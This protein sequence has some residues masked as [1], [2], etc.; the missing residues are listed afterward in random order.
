MPS[1]IMKTYSLNGK[2]L[3]KMVKFQKD[4]LLGA[5]TAAHQVEGGN[6]HSD[7][8]ALENIPHTAY[9]E[10]SGNA[11]DHYHRY[12]EDIRMLEK[13]GFN[14]YRFS[15]EWARIEPEEGKFD[16][17][18]IEHYRRVIRCCKAHRIEPMITLLHFSSPAWLISK[19]GWETESVIDDFVRYCS[20]VIEH[21]G[22]EVKYVCTINELNIRLQIA[23]IIQ[24]YSQNMMRAHKQDPSAERAEDE[25]QMG[26]N[27]K[28]LM[29]RQQ[30]S[31]EEG[32]DVFGLPD[33]SQMHVF[34]S[35]CSLAGDLIL[36]KA[37]IAARGAIKKICPDLKVGLT[38]SLHDFQAQQ[39]GEKMA[40]KEWDKEF[41]HYLPFIS[42]DD[43]L[44]VQNYTRTL[45]GPEGILPFPENAEL[46]QT[47]YEYYPEALEHVVR[48]VA[49]G[50]SGP[51][52]VT[53]NGIATDNDDRRIDFISTAAEGVSRCIA[54]GISVKGYFYWSLLDNFEWQKGFSKTFGLI[55]VDRKTMK[56]SPKKSLEFLG[57]MR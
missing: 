51:I 32:A 34:Q 12:E 10:R 29:E 40:E 19:G 49:E 2:G 31:E 45:V 14:A 1:P 5:A 57:N 16:E 22:S 48:K 4:F 56:R 3:N 42:A 39:G 27:M 53:E 43:F 50:F 20:Y 24:R 55:A 46:T 37:H 18:E 38:L 28:A 13:A 8:W 47:G 44:G 7:C 52:Y 41:T 23:D 35:P 15:I 26:M 11:V 6:V 17:K 36:C 21:L 54:D 33:A 30:L 25:L 9:A